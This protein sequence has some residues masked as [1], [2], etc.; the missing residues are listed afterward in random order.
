MSAKLSLTMGFEAADLPRIQSAIGEFSQEQDWPPDIEFQVDLVL[1]ELVL[2]VVH[3]GSSDGE[4]GEIK[5]ELFSDA[6]SVVIDII[7]SG[8][9]FDPLTDA[10]EPDTESTI[11]DRAVGGLGIHL[12]RTMMDEVTYRREENKNHMRLVKRR[13]E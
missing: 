3:H 10:P 8:R 12:V 5:I 9:P 13:N 6:E 4:E 11:E 7:D 2:N 1:E